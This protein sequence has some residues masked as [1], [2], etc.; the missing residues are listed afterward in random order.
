[1]NRAQCWQDILPGQIVSAKVGCGL[2]RQLLQQTNHSRGCANWN[3]LPQDS[4]VLGPVK[5]LRNC[6]RMTAAAPIVFS[7]ADILHERRARARRARNR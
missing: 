5:N 6:I 2:S 4:R 1:M 7:N 3:F